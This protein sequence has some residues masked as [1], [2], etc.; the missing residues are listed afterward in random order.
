MF[1]AVYVSAKV[2][3]LA[4]VRS[5]PARSSLRGYRV[6]RKQR[7]ATHV[8][9]ALNDSAAILVIIGPSWAKSFQQRAGGPDWMQFE[10]EQALNLDSAWRVIPVLAR[11][12]C[13]GH[14]RRTCHERR[15]RIDRRRSG[16]RRH[17]MGAPDRQTVLQRNKN[18]DSTASIQDPIPSFFTLSDANR[19]G[20]RNA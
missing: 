12:R 4:T 15:N 14:G 19:C 11:Q 9:N 2:N 5:R 13:G 8:I 3:N 7:Q 6:Q 20:H 10:V 16:D 1:P 17:R 18:V